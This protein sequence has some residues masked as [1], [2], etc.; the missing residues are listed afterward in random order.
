MILIQS[1]VGIE[2]AEGLVGQPQLLL[3]GFTEG[4]GQFHG[5]AFQHLDHAEKCGRVATMNTVIQIGHHQLDGAVWLAMANGF[6]VFTAGGQIIQNPL[7]VAVFFFNVFHQR[8]TNELET[9][10][11][12]AT[13]GH[14]QRNGVFYM[15][16][17]LGQ[18]PCIAFET[19]AAIADGFNHRGVGHMGAGFCGFG[20]QSVKKCHIG[21]SWRYIIGVMIRGNWCG[22]GGIH[23]Q[24]KGFRHQHRQ[25]SLYLMAN[26]TAVGGDVALGLRQWL[27]ADIHGF[28]PGIIRQAG[29]QLSQV[30]TQVVRRSAITDQQQCAGLR[31]TIPE[32]HR[33]SS[34]QRLNQLAFEPFRADIAAK[35]GN[36]QILCTPIHCQVTVRADGSKVSGVQPTIGLRLVT[37][38]T[39]EGVA[40]HQDTALIIHPNLHMGQRLA[41]RAFALR[42]RHIQRHYRTALRQAITFVKRQARPTSSC[43]QIWRYPAA[44]DRQKTQSLG[45]EHALLGRPE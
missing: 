10:R 11:Q 17:G 19:E 29:I 36:Q 28:E 31:F 41:H 4:C 8:L 21:C 3:N 45:S 39:Q 38:I 18:K 34:A 12:P 22:P 6:L 26:G 13:T 15:M 37:Q 30:R 1:A 2:I 24:G 9:F 33:L 27:P 20:L 5:S 44:A 42:T 25:V 16:V 32:H 43:Q 40:A 35:T 23:E 7:V 14:H